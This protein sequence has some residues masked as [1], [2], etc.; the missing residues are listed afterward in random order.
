MEARIVKG[1]KLKGNAT[2]KY[3]IRFMRFKMFMMRNGGYLAQSNRFIYLPVMLVT[4][5]SKSILGTTWTEEIASL[6][7]YNG[8]VDK[9]KRELHWRVIHMEVGR[10]FFHIR[11]MNNLKSPRLLATHLPYHLLPD[12]LKEGKGKVRKPAD[13]H[14]TK[15]YKSNS[16]V[17]NWMW[18]RTHCIQD[19]SI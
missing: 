4:I 5:S 13:T 12:Q 11:F 8:D 7:K 18:F 10:P 9:V 15:L 17:N 16:H 19:T 1:R 14:F 3:Q 6:V 2:K